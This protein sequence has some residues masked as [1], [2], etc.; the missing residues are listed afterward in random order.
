MNPSNEN[1]INLMGYL[2]IFFR[3]K[4]LFIIPAFAGLII[5]I[6]LGIILPKKYVS[7]TILMVEEGKSDNPLF[8]NLAVSSTV[9][10]R[11]TAIR[12]SMLGWNSLVKLVKRLNLDKNVK[13]P[14][15][16]E[17]LV[18]GIR[19]NIIIKLRGNNII[20]L[21]YVGANP[22]MTQAVV[23]NI[24]E[25]FIE[26]N[27]DI[28]NQ[29]TSDAIA[30]IE[31]Q[32]KV[33]RGKIKSAEIAK[34]RESLNILLVDSTEEHPR[35]KQLREEVA[36]KEEELKREN[37]QYTE[38]IDLNTRTTNTI[39]SE[40]KSALDKIDG[41]TQASVGASGADASDKDIYKVMLID[42]LDT[43][44]ARDVDVN[45]QI[46]NTLLQRLETAKIT[47]RLQSSKEGTKYTILDPP[48]IPLA[49]VQPNKILV[50]LAGLL[51]GV[52]IGAGLVITA[53][54]LDKSFIDVEDAKQFLGVPLLGA[55]SRI[56]TEQ[57]IRLEK[58]RMAWMYS[59]MVIAGALAV[60]VSVAVSNIIKH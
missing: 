32:L 7:S 53:E 10:Q 9:L 33:Y 29:E 17:G 28:Q 31:E 58:E 36:A 26:R 8:D 20:D 34:L 50:T 25:I 19:K 37:L 21:S 38:N 52:I 57:S 55:I 1:M 18:L 51:A 48:R 45:N 39:I 44:M 56:N 4:E 12:E 13:T 47:Q 30:F 24:T 2:K 42:K 60:M 14:Q 6:S 35:V 49:P 3:R 16:L 27:L 59:L 54:F 40:I 15:D 22:E 41:G 5:G 46:Y 43:V 23:K 11:M